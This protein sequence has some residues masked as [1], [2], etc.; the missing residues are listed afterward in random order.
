MKSIIIALLAFG[1]FHSDG[2]LKIVSF[3]E[4]EEIIEAPSDGIRVYNF[5]ATWCAPCI[6]EMPHFQTVSRSEG[7]ELMF[8]SLD[9]GRK[10]DRVENFM[11]KRNITSPVVLLDDID[12][13]RWIGKVSDDWSG[14]IPATLFIDAN[15]KRH[16]H[17]GEMSEQELK[18]FI[19]KLK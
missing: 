4:F 17:E 12:Y 6:K 9:D 18:D 5:W 14:A 15:G 2:K 10:P 3:E 19:N 13:N 11:E 16:F 7:V 8:V 1:L